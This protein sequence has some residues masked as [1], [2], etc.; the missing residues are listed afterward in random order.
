MKSTMIILL[1]FI[2]CIFLY[3]LQDRQLVRNLCRAGQRPNYPE[4]DEAL[5]PVFRKLHSQG[6]TEEDE[7]KLLFL[8]EVILKLHRAKTR[9]NL[10]L[11]HAGRSNLTVGGSNPVPVLRQNTLY[12]SLPRIIAVTSKL[13]GQPYKMQGEW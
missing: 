3:S 12:L 7:N 9:Y 1:S 10:T 11:F 8:R 6:I 4:T 13:L 5:V 2:Y